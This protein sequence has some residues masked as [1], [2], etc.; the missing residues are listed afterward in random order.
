M[1]TMSDLELNTLAAQAMGWHTGRPASKVVA[2]PVSECAIIAG[3]E[4]GGESVYDPLHDDAQAMALVKRF[5]KEFELGGLLRHVFMEWAELGP[6]D[7]NRAIVQ[8][9]AHLHQS[10]TEGGK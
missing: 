5:R 9:V 8:C 10:K 2:Y 1:R 4:Q 6:D 3:N 7:L